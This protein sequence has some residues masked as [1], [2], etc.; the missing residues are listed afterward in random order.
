RVKAGDTFFIEVGRVHAI[1]KGILLAEIQQTS[2]ITYRIY[3]WD[4]VDA[5]GNSRELH[6][7][8]AID[9]IDFSMPDNYKV[10]YSKHQNTSDPFVTCPYFTTPY[11]SLT[12]LLHEEDTFDSFLIYMCVEGCVNFIFEG[13]TTKVKTGETIL[14]PAALKQ[15]EIVPEHAS[16][17]L[18]IYI[19]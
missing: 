18:E 1:G 9:A 11:L 12:V 5:A 19:P 15:F 4:R 6:T 14:L 2:D 17:L 16:K 10:A 3:D 13:T 7:D 8:L